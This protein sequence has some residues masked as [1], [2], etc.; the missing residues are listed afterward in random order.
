MCLL[1]R[2]EAR[3][4][5]WIAVV[6]SYAVALQAMLAGFA[7]SFSAEEHSFAH[8]PFVVCSASGHGPAGEGPGAPPSHPSHPSHDAACA[9][10]CSMV[11]ASPALPSAGVG[12]RFVASVHIAHAARSRAATAFPRRFSPRQSQG[13]PPTA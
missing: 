9:L 13:P 1:P 4:R 12:H 10:L 5:P 2:A 7:T 6:A 11:A 3:V 8:D